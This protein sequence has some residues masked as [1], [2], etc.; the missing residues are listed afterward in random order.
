MYCW[1]LLG[2]QM[3]VLCSLF[4]LILRN[5]LRCLLWGVKC[6]PSYPR[7][8]GQQTGPQRSSV[9]LA[10]SGSGPSLPVGCCVTL[11]KRT[12]TALFKADARKTTQRRPDLE[13]RGWP[14]SKDTGITCIV[15]VSHKCLLTSYREPN[16]GPKK[17]Y[18]WSLPWG[19]MDFV[20]VTYRSMGEQL[21][22]QR[23]FEDSWITEAHPSMGDG[24]QKMM[25][26]SLLH[27]LQVVWKVGECLSLL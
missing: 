3:E 7:F 9:L 4:V 26:W 21:W 22:D 20:G 15:P 24:T 19:T 14:L 11:H 5:E 1:C 6:F 12:A 23:W 18:H 10:G 2:S 16:G 25:S 17:G 13:T 8:K 27:S